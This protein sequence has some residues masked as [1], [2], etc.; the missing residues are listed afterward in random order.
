M[1]GWMDVKKQGNTDGTKNEHEHHELRLHGTRRIGFFYS[2][3][4]HSHS[5]SSGSKTYFSKC[6][7]F[8]PIP[9]TLPPSLTPFS[10]SLT[11]TPFPVPDTN[12]R[13]ASP[14]CA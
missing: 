12:P 13:L 5:S 9:S 3:M 8:N 14:R 2:L 1:D 4:S 6:H 11:H 7:I 10:Q